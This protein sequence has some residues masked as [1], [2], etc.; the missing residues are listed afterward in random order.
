MDVLI[1]YKNGATTSME[2]TQAHIAQVQRAIDGTVYFCEDE[3]EALSR[4]IDADVLV[5]WGGSGKHNI[6][7]QWCRQSKKLKWVHTLSSGYELIT[8][9][10]IWTMPVSITNTSGIHG[11]TIALTV[12]GYVISF[13][14]QFPR[15]YRLQMAH[16]WER[17]L[18]SLPADTEGLTACVIG[19]GAVGSEIAKKLRMIG[20]RTIGVKR[21]V[22][23][24]PYFDAVLGSDQI[25]EAVRDADFVI[26]SVP[27]TD[28]TF[29]MVNKDFLSQLKPGTFLINVSRGSV[30]DETALISALQAKQ[31][32]G[33]AMDVA[34][35]EPLPPDSPLWDFDNILI[36]PHM[37][38][39]SAQYMDRAFD[40]LCTNISRFRDGLPLSNEV[41]PAAH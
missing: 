19:A 18:P 22:S 12:L 39:V 25:R 31:I 5:F 41:T 21:Q 9:S 10:P 13:L 33:A 7:T 38:A 8:Q 36:T 2:L 35:T 23:P 20:M 4:S 29:H 24:L 11:Q 28:A 14:R 3:R 1:L 27:L 15:L 26:L 32:A 6:P 16:K 37:S 34:E 17:P 40:Q 30:V